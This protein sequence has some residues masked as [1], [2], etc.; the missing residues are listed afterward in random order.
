MR[1]A[2]RHPGGVNE[3]KYKNERIVSSGWSDRFERD[4][5]CVIADYT[6]TFYFFSSQKLQAVQCLGTDTLSLKT[7]HH[8]LFMQFK[9]TAE[10]IFA[11]CFYN[12]P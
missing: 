9:I 1:P 5:S 6:A 11:V 3:K 2:N 10:A 7:C 8:R 12:F 4:D